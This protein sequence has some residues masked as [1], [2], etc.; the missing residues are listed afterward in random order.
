MTRPNIKTLLSCLFGAVGLMVAMLAYDAISSMAAIHHRSAV[1]ATEKMPKG[2]AGRALEA[3]FH[4]VNFANARLILA[5]TPTEMT[6]AEQSVALRT[7]TLDAALAAYGQMFESAEG[8]TLVTEL[9]N[10]V[11]AYRKPLQ[12]MLALA[13]ANKDA[14]ANTIFFSQM[15]PEVA[16]VTAALDKL[17]EFNDGETKAT[18]SEGAVAYNS[19][20]TMIYLVVGLTA[21]IVTAAVYFSITSIAK[22]IQTITASMQALAAGDTAKVI[23]YAGR[24]DEIGGMA[25]AV[26]IFRENA[27]TNIR[28]EEESAAQ[29]GL[30]EQERLRN[31]AAEKIAAA[32]MRQA[33]TGLGLGLKH[34]ASGDLFFQLNEAF[35]PDFESLRADFNASVSQLADVLGEVAQSAHSI[36]GGTR[37]I[38]ISANDL[39]RRTEQQA[40]SLEQTAAALD[41]ITVNVSNS[42]KR[43][44]EARLVAIEASASAAKSG[45]VV[46]EAVGAMQKIEQSSNEISSIIGVI[47][48][49]AFQTNLLALNAGVEAARAGEAGKGFAV[50]AQ[51]V[52]ELAQRSATAAKEIKTLIGTSAVEVSG[53]VK[54]VRETGEALAAIQNYV[55]TINK[56]M[57]SIATSSREQSV[58]LGEVNTAVNQMD[59]VTQQNAAMVEET[60]AASAT[61]AVEGGRLKDQIARFRFSAADSEQAQPSHSYAA[62]RAA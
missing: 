41:Q 12:E 4:R 50:V 27:L 23:P 16:K 35:A 60:N 2:I 47:D 20:T 14:E 38:S 39:A 30:T 32:A 31:E 5:S 24:T 46:A 40:A 21:L 45:A 51:E 10:A 11:S 53:G 22:P 26:E 8:Q 62:R 57:D 36:D 37:E 55:A 1:I 3:A 13:R 9:T 28:L 42:S 25:A 17:I 43:A 33:T 59:Q 15:F 19:A 49:I 61:L 58:G 44:E 18:L 7:R 56:H 48:E 52:R 6:D 29:R 54:L 34:L